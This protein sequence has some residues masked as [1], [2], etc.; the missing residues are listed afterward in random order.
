MTKDELKN[1]QS[2]EREEAISYAQ[3]VFQQNQELQ[4]TLSAGEEDYLKTTDW[5]R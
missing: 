1:K 3:K 5:L 2:R 4:S